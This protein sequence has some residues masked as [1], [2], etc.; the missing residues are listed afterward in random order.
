MCRS[1]FSKGFSFKVFWSRFFFF[2]PE[3]GRG[4]NGY[5]LHKENFHGSNE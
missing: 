4:D 3:F 2:K 1:L 5:L